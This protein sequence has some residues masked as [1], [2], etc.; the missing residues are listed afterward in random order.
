MSDCRCCDR[1]GSH[2]ETLPRSA[3]RGP[4]ERPGSENVPASHRGPDRES[5]DRRGRS[6]L[7]RGRV[8]WS[9]SAGPLHLIQAVVGATDR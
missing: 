7:V 4:L 1:R 6:S 8:G 5:E 3:L 9:S 2:K